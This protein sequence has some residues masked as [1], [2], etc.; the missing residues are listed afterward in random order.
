MPFCN[1]FDWNPRSN[2][3]L[4]LIRFWQ[5]W[6]HALSCNSQHLKR[7]TSSTATF[8]FLCKF[9]KVDILIEKMWFK[10]AIFFSMR[11][12]FLLWVANL[13][14]KLRMNLPFLIFKSEAFGQVVIFTLIFQSKFAIVD[15]FKNPIDFQWRICTQNMMFQRALFQFIEKIK[16]TV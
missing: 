15:V 3:A 7:S 5:I 13:N 1:C 2:L 10:F 6:V 12:C 14:G 11:S 16:K 9:G 4:F 8:G